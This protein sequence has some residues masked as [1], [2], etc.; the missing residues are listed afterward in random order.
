MILADRFAL[1]RVK[2]IA[3]GGSFGGDW[4]DATDMEWSGMSLLVGLRV[5]QIGDGLAA[6]IC[7]RLLADIG[8]DVSCIGPDNAAPLARH[9]NHGKTIVSGKAEAREAVAAADLVICEGGPRDLHTR[10]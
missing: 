10:R 3:V 7:G 6:A 5:V 9:L 2:R 1:D 8:A 4:A